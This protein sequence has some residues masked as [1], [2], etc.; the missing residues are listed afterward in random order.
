MLIISTL[1]I[2]CGFIG[3]W[4][5]RL[6]M[7]ENEFSPVIPIIIFMIIGIFVIVT[8]SIVVSKTN[9]LRFLKRLGRNTY[10]IM[11]FSQLLTAITGFFV[12]N[13]YIRYTLMIMSLVMLIIAI[14]SVKQ[15]QIFESLRAKIVRNFVR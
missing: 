12:V 3:G 14:N 1:L 11:A 4:F 13:P 9:S 10:E 5:W 8:L 15:S 2:V 6:D 7:A